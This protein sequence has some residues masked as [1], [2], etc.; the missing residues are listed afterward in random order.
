MLNFLDPAEDIP[1]CQSNCLRNQKLDSV[2]KQ[3]DQNYGN[4][5]LSCT[6]KKQFDRNVYIPDIT[7]AGLCY[8][9]PLI[10]PSG[11]PLTDLSATVL[12]S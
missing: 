1:E 8:T 2:T 7:R 9:M 11:L 6:H 12:N 10:I 3:Y 4:F 5:I